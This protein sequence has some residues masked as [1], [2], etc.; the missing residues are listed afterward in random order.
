MY[1]KFHNF[2]KELKQHLL[3]CDLGFKETMNNTSQIKSIIIVSKMK[4]K[5]LSLIMILYFIIFVEN[6]FIPPKKKKLNCEVEDAIELGG[7]FK[8]LIL[9]LI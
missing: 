2:C 4:K 6:H 1:I 7:F 5:K 8:Y 9:Q 3:T